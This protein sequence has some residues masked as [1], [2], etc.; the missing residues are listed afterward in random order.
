M[1]VKASHIIKSALHSCHIK[2][3]SE[4]IIIIII[5]LI[6]NFKLQK[7]MTYFDDKNYGK[8]RLLNL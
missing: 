8:F 2:I 6:R 3:N 5:K 1:C 4:T 7:L